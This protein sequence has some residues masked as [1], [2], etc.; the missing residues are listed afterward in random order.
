M[1][2]ALRLV[3]TARV[4]HYFPCNEMEERSTTILLL[5][6]KQHEY[7]HYVFYVISRGKNE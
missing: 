5:G 1:S 2:R 6:I 4:G 7:Y 3:S